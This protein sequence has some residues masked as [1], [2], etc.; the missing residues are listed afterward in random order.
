LNAFPSVSLQ[1]ANQPTPG[2]GCLSLD[3]P[4]RERTFAIVASM[5]SVSKY[6]SRLP[7]S[8]A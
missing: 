1:F 2:T 3:S 5:S 7:D 4:P 6:K 8:P